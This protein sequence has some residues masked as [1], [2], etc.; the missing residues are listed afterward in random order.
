MRHAVLISLALA[1]A[2]TPALAADMPEHRRV[3][4]LFEEPR[5]GRE[6]VVAEQRDYVPL[7]PRKVEGYYGTPTSFQQRNY[8][9]TGHNF[10]YDYFPYACEALNTCWNRA[11]Q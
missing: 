1:A 6:I 2:A 7:I 11:K 4:R 9:G 10:I 3:G 5:S 8:Y